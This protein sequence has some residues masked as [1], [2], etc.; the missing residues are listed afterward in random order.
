MEKQ[1]QLEAFLAA[2]GREKREIFKTLRTQLVAADVERIA[3]AIRDPSPKL[4]ARVTSLL[5]RHG[6]EDLLEKHLVGLKPGKI[7]ILRGKFQRIASAAKPAVASGSSG[8]VE[9]SPGD[10]SPESGAVKDGATE[11]SASEGGE[12]EHSV[13]EPAAAVEDDPPAHS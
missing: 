1:Q 12:A 6:R 7:A 8:G 10:A 11:G 2:S 13:S 3:I 4:S 5:A 9:S